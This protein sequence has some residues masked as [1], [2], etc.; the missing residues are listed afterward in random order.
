MWV[1]V[2]IGFYPVM[3]SLYILVSNGVG[4]EAFNNQQP[5]TLSELM[6][7]FLHNGTGLQ[8]EVT[9]LNFLVDSVTIWQRQTERA[10]S[11]KTAAR[12]R[13]ATQQCCQE[14]QAQ[15]NDAEEGAK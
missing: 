10:V 2:W 9:F 4:V 14:Q 7:S 5:A 12:L 15:N 6:C 8:M 13:V 1:F 3:L 11:V